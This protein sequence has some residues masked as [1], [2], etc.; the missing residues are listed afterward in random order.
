MNFH[1]SSDDGQVGQVNPTEANRYLVRVGLGIAVIPTV[2]LV[3][4]LQTW[5]WLPLVAGSLTVTAGLTGLAGP[6]LRALLL[7]FCVVASVLPSAHRVWSTRPG[8]PVVFVVEETFGG[9]RIEL[10]E[11]PEAGLELPL[12]EGSWVVK[13]PPSG[14][15]RI[16]DNSMFALPHRESCRLTNG[17]LCAVESLAIRWGDGGSAIGTW[18]FLRVKR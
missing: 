15:L 17:E 4:M 16:K 12:V 2:F 18:S 7:G 5:F 13:V 9:S 3:L 1:R 11:D 8:K 10:V 6:R 14:R